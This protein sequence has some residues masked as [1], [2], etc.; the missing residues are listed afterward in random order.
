MDPRDGLR[1]MKFGGAA[2][3]DASGFARVA[4]IVATSPAPRVVVTSAMRQVTDNL[5]TTLPAIQRDESQVFVL[6]ESLRD[7]HQQALARVAPKGDEAAK[8]A[9]ASQLERLE[10]L[11][12]GIAYTQEA[13]PRLRDLVLSFGERLAAPILAAALRAQGS[14]AVAL[15]AE[16]AGI[17]TAGPFGNARPDLPA[18]RREAPQRLAP[19]LDAGAIPVVT[20]YYGVDGQGN[21]TLFGRGGSDYV[22]SLL[23][24]ALKASRIELWKDVPGFLSADPRVVPQARLVPELGY[25]EAAELAHFGAKVLHARA[26][27]PAEQAGIPIHIRSVHEPEATGSIIHGRA[28]AGTLVRSI[29]SRDELGVVKLSGPGMGATPGVAKRVFDALAQERLNVLN[30]AT[31]QASFALL[32]EEQDLEAARQAL[33][34]LVGGVV[35]GIDVLRGRSLVCVVGKGLGST[36]G[37]AARVLAAVG[38]A[39]VNIEMI[40]V[41]ASEIAIDLIVRSEQRPAAVQGIHRMQQDVASVRG[42]A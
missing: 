22:A 38:D 26:V 14:A 36:T 37:S 39:G 29:A 6:I 40:S 13:T 28:G 25:D 5:A 10:R 1:I 17:R 18:L 12:Y 33:S 42:A 41:A 35:Q 16:H 3:A 34:P 27:E 31:S 23:G 4:T 7:R 8:Y 21:A 30:M 15:D 9:L 24:Y 32:M 20:G 11:L 2:L 19:H